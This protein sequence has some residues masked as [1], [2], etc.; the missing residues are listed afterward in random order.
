MTIHAYD[1]V[2]LTEDLRATHPES[3]APILLRR[4][5]VGTVL[6]EFDGAACLIDFSDGEGQTYAMETVPI[7]KL[8]VLFYEPVL[9]A[10]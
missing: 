1:V 7:E 4:G 5:Q 6:M 2:A 9:V 3:K 10:A 8:M